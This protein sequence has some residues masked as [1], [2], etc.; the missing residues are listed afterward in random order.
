M[1]WQLRRAIRPGMI[2]D[3]PHGRNHL[4]SECMLK[5]GLFE[6]LDVE[7]QGSCR[8]SRAWRKLS[9]NQKRISDFRDARV[10]HHHYH[11]IV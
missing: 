6:S 5:D 7:V 9:A 1:H 2:P 3:S 11:N 8:V 10:K 4:W